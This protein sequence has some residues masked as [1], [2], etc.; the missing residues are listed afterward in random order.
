M[1]PIVVP[2]LISD[3]LE[4][5]D[6][7]DLAKQITNPQ[8]LRDLGTKGLKVQEHIINAALTDNKGSIQGAAY[9]VLSTWSKA[10]P[11]RRE[12][13]VKLQAALKEVHIDQPAAC[14]RSEGT[15]EGF[16]LTDESK[17]AFYG[18]VLSTTYVVHQ[19]VMFS[20]VSVCLFTGGA[21]PVMYQDRL[22][23]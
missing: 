15:A 20:V 6:I 16:K 5:S 4:D 8:K 3:T 13:K 10:Q 17:W 11:S 18:G 2:F 21:Y 1:L 7:L 14:P 12:A 19:K 9:S 22:P 23:Q